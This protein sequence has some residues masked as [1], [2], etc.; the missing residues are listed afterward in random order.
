MKVLMFA[1]SQA[2]APHSRT[3]GLVAQWLGLTCGVSWLPKLSTTAS[4]QAETG[5]KTQQLQ[6]ITSL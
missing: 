3:G 2:W 6:P 5:N 4:H 1:V